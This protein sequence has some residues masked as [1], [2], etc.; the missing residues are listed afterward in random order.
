[1]KLRYIITLILTTFFLTVGCVEEQVSFDLS[2]VQ[3]SKSYINIPT[4]GGSIDITLTTTA[5]WAIKGLLKKE[6]NEEGKYEHE[7]L[8][9]WLTI[10]KIEGSAN[11][12]GEKITFSADETPSDRS[13]DLLILVGDKEQNLLV[14]QVAGAP[15]L[16]I[17]TVAEALAAPDGKVL[18]VEGVVT[19]ISN[20]LY[21]N[22]DLKDDTGSIYI[23]GTLD[24]NGA[25]KNFESL[26]LAEGDKVK[27]SLPRSSY[28]GKPQGKNVTILEI[29]KSLITV[30]PTSVKLGVEGGEFEVK[31]CVKGNG[32]GVDM[33]DA[34]WLSLRSQEIVKDTTVV[35]LAAIANDTYEKREAVINFSSSK[36]GETSTISVNVEQ[37][38]IPSADLTLEGGN[39][40]SADPLDGTF[41]ASGATI[42]YS[43]AYYSSYGSYSIGKDTDGYF[44]NLTEMNGLSKIVAIDDYKY[45]NL[46]LYVGAT[47]DKVDTK[48]EMTQEGDSRIFNIAEGNKF[49]KF[50][51]ESSHN[52]QADKIEFYY[53]SLGETVPGSDF[54]E[55]P[56]PEVGEIE[57]SFEDFWKAA[58]FA[59]AA[60]A[61]EKAVLDAEF[62]DFTF[63]S[64]KGTASTIFRFWTDD[65]RSYAGNTVTITA[66]NGK[67]VKGVT[68]SSSEISAATV[69]TA[70]GKSWT[71][72]AE[73]VTLT[74]GSGKNKS[75]TIDVQ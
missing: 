66:K 4:K 47:A 75:I 33:G 23:Y 59:D 28:N 12:K 48:V 32:L 11:P 10:S 69:G 1:M 5:D 42:E 50:V 40:M 35:T 18:I 31:V 62:P 71:G 64:D 60:S 14:K 6:K 39:G 49:F 22:W 19:N 68:F 74:L 63:T 72:D 55:D 37:A 25:E 58:G 7:A 30:D 38:P 29:T 65:I 73:S 46:T 57:Y 67:K 20:T 21:G 3:V 41:E 16:T 56:T 15:D 53:D 13:V 9:D 54:K 27:V 70:D 8:P 52:A 26:G 2:E 36:D 17:A 51:N 61:K 34:S 24:K 44:R 43:K 45:F